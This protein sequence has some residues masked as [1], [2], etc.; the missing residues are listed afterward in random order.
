MRV[1]EGSTFSEEEWKPESPTSGPRL[2][3][4]PAQTGPDQP[5]PA[6]KGPDWRRPPQTSPDRPRAAQT[7][8]DLSRPAQ[9]GPAQPRPAQTNPDR[10]RLAQTGPDQPRPAQQTSSNISETPEDLYF[11]PTK[12][13]EIESLDVMFETFQGSFQDGGVEGFV[14]WAEPVQVCSPSPLLEEHLLPPPGGPTP[15]ASSPSPSTEEPRPFLSSVCALPLQM[16]IPLASHIVHRKDIPCETR[17]Q[18]SRLP[19]GLRLDTSTP[20]RAVQ[21]WT[22]VQIQRNLLTQTFMQELFHTVPNKDAVSRR[23]PEGA[24]QA[25]APLG[26]HLSRPGRRARR[27]AEEMHPP[28]REAENLPRDQRLVGGTCS[29]TCR[30]SRDGSCTQPTHRGCPVSR[31]GSKVL[32]LQEEGPESEQGLA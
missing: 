20:Y 24:S 10:L 23:V 30:R 25:L 22:D 3:G 5:R 9:T 32:M 31:A 19:S 18:C 4:F 7:G 29:C 16:A 8:S 14:Y 26:L 2:L 6:Q 17:P 11:D 15:P 1:A 28:G 27:P 12:L 13:I 21:S